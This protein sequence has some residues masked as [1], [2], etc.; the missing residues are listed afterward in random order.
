MKTLLTASALLLAGSLT[1]A[2]FNSAQA[3]AP[4]VTPTAPVV[5]AFTVDGGHSSVLFKIKHKDTAYA[6]GR[7][8]QVSGTINY[9]SANPAKSSVTV[10]IP[11]QS[12][13]TN[14][15]KRDEHL[16]GPDFLDAKQF[17]E[18]K[19]T[20]KSVKQVGDTWQ[21]KGTMEFHGTRKEISI[22]FEKTGESAGRGGG[23]V[24]GFHSVFT[25]DR[26]DWGIDYGIGALGKEIE[27]TV[28]LE[29][30]GK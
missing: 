14:S 12:V 6:Y 1:L 24:L 2:A 17:P 25:I 16:L 21:A 18:L 29:L 28:S 20:S 19:F 4:V 10:T 5:G 15:K 26:T 22:D 3:M 30:T 27:V 8:N 7:F 13:D 11:T 9:D 23:K